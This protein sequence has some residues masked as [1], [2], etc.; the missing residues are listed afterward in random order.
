MTR[1]DV[2]VAILLRCYPAAWR[3]EYGDELRHILE[4]RP[5][6]AAIVIDVAVSGLRQRVRSASPATILG[7]VSMLLVMSQFLVASQ[8]WPAAVRP[9]G[10]TF[11]TLRVTFLAS[12]LSVY[13]G[14]A[15]GYWTERRWP[16]SLSR[17]GLASA[18]MAFLAGSPVMIAGM[19]LAMGFVDSDVALLVGRRF[20][21]SSASMIFSPLAVAPQFWMW[22]VIG[23]WLKQRVDRVRASKRQKLT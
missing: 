3:R 20:A 9:S 21:P 17:A 16:G 15:C 10:I 6:T 4:S 2:V 11:P 7:S 23:G 22:G 1:R 5:I 8:Y 14:I 18:K 12:E 13:I 19:L